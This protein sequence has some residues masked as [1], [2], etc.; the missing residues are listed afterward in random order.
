LSI[1][2]SSQRQEEGDG[3]IKTKENDEIC[4]AKRTVPIVKLEEG[5]GVRVVRNFKGF[6]SL[7]SAV[8]GAVSVFIGASG[9]FFAFLKGE[10]G[11]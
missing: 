8:G 1:T 5:F 4:L 2:L 10:E 7:L 6:W 3:D 9:G 11:V